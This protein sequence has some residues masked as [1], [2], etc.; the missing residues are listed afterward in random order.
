MKN[1]PV[2]LVDIKDIN[3]D[4]SFKIVSRSNCPIHF[5]L[6]KYLT[7]HKYF[8]KKSKWYPRSREFF[9]DV[10]IFSEM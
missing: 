10:I 7:Y 8:Q 9:D 3:N 4:F 5:K 6:G 2:Y 1:I